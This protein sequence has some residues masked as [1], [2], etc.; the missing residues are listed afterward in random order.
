MFLSFTTIG[1]NENDTIKIIAINIREVGYLV[2]YFSVSMLI[3]GDLLLPLQSKSE[4]MTA[5]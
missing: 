5:L 2:G 4:I 1:L 3:I